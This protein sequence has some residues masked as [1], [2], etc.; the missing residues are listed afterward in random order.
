[1]EDIVKNF[2]EITDRRDSVRKKGKETNLAIETARNAEAAK[3][4]SKTQVEGVEREEVR[5]P[6]KQFRQI[7]GVLPTKVSQDFLPFLAQEWADDMKLYI[8]T[9]SNFDI[10]SRGDQRTLCKRF[11]ESSLWFLVPFHQNVDNIAMRKRK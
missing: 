7:T 1:M 8:R 10:L 6:D 5:D 2:Q 9:C 11:V 4:T 3:R